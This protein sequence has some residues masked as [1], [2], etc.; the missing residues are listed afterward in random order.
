MQISSSAIIL[1]KNT[2]KA[3]ASMTKDWLGEVPK[4][5]KLTVGLI[6]CPRDW[7]WQIPG[8]NEEITGY[9]YKRLRS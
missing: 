9:Y 1:V 7:Q 4:F 8:G 2:N 5:N 6:Y 3:S